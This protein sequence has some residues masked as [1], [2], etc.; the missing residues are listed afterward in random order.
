M[1][2]ATDAI[3]ADRHQIATAQLTINGKIENDSIA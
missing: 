1:A 2:K 3:D